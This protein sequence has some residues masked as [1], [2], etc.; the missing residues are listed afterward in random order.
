MS[1]SIVIIINRLLFHKSI[2]ANNHKSVTGLVFTS[3]VGEFFI[4]T[5]FY[6]QVLHLS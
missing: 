2:V 3:E 5:N 4:L 6:K 1:L